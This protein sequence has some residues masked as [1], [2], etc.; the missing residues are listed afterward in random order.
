MPQTYKTYGDY[1]LWKS[2]FLMKIVVSPIWTNW[3]AQDHLLV[4]NF[5]QH[6]TFFR[7]VVY[8]CIGEH[9][10]NACDP[11]VYAVLRF[12]QFS[13]EILKASAN[14]HH[15][16]ELWVTY[17]TI[18]LILLIYVVLPVKNNMFLE[19]KAVRNEFLNHLRTNVVFTW[20]SV[21][22]GQKQFE[23]TIG[24]TRSST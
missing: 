13:H 12:M 21:V 20:C 15:T 1:E 22:T 24:H 8:I 6:K 10:N 11:V 16:V 3:C 19:M 23:W 7:L 18:H 5:T 9:N 17:T 14:R 2:L 4:R